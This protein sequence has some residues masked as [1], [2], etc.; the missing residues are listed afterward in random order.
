MI[1][2][3]NQIIRSMKSYEEGGSLEVTKSKKKKIT[4]TKKK[5]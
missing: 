3:K 2:D 1:H 5:K 4:L